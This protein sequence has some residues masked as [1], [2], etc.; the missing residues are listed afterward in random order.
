[1]PSAERPDPNRTSLERTIERAEPI[2]RKDDT[3]VLVIF[4]VDMKGSTALK[5]SIRSLRRRYFFRRPAAL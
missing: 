3:S 2:G 5:E 1:M 4:F